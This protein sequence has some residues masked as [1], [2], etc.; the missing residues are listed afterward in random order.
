MR[1]SVSK[2]QQINNIRKRE[3][4]TPNLNEVKVFTLLALLS[5]TLLSFVSASHAESVPKELLGFWTLQLESGEPAWMSVAESDGRAVVRMRVYIGPDGPFEV[6]EITDGQI[7]FSLKPKRKE[8]GSK[9]FTTRDVE[10]GL[11]DGKLA[12]VIIHTPND[13][14][15]TKR[16]AFTGKPVPAMPKPAPDLSK[17]RFGH[18]ISLF[19]GKDLS[20]WRPHESDKINGW[21]VED[22]MLVNNTTKTDFSPT[23][24]YAN[25]RT[26]AEHEDFWL[27]IEFLVEKDRNSGIYL[28]GMYE[29]QVVDRDSKMQGLQGVGAIFGKIAPTSQAGHPGG[30]W[31]TY[32]LT[33][34]DR[35][36]TVVLNGVKVIDNQPID[37]P[38]AGA[39][40]TDPSAPGPIY[41]QGD[42]T[43]VK[44]KNIYLAPVVDAN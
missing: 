20:G 10:V 26:V 41:L 3:T 36:I 5:G 24:A 31:Q 35:H 38:T 14:G 6:K 33:L 27:H 44:Y 32:D 18:P 34:V 1:D 4:M 7:K 2:R 11:K 40:Y 42:H 19:N 23:G 8:K 43:A 16:V 28:R 12:G 39:I 29:A 37:S 17:V 9:V 13:G 25:L 21:S 22:G 15:E 30:K